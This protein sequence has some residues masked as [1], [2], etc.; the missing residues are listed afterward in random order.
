[1]NIDAL[2]LSDSGSDHEGQLS[3][4]FIFI[5]VPELSGG[6]CWQSLDCFA[7]PNSTE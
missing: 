1:M 5:T 4:L 6:P 3:L 7:C 2:A